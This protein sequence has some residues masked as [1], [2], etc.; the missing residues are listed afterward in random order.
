MMESERAS[1][2]L[3]CSSFPDDGIGIDLGE[4]LDYFPL[5]KE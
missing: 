1:A 5:L 2:K 3:F 4:T